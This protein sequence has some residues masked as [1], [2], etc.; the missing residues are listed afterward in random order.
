M[1]TLRPY[2]QAALDA[3]K[4]NIQDH[5]YAALPTGSGKSHVIAHL[6]KW[7][8]DFDETRVVVLT[9]TKELLQ[10]NMEKI[11][12]L[13][14]Y[15]DSSFYCAGLSEKK[16]GTITLASVQSLARIISDLPPVDLFI[17]DEAHRIPH[18]AVGQYR[19]IFAS[20]PGARV[21]GLTATPYRMNGGYLHE[22]EDAIFDR[23][24]YNCRT[25][26]LIKAGYL[27]DIVSK[28]GSH[29][30]DTGGLHT[31]Q[32]EFIV[33]E[34]EAV[35]DTVG[36]NDSMVQDILTRASDRK[37]IMVFCCTVQ[38]CHN[39]AKE[40]RKAG[41]TGVDV[42]TGMTRRHER[43]EAIE[44]FKT[45]AT[46][47]LVNCDVLTTGF[48][49]PR[50]DT[51]VLLRATK[52]PGLYVQIVGRGLRKAEGK[53]NCLLLD[54][55]GN[56]RR[57]GTID[58]LNIEA[59]DSECKQAEPK[60]CPECGLYVA[61]GKRECPG[62]GY[63][64][65]REERKISLSIKADNANPVWAEIL[66]HEVREITY[67]KHDKPGKPPSLRVDYHVGMIQRVPEWI[68]VEHNGY[69]QERAAAWFARRGM[70]MPKT[71]DEALKISPKL[72]APKR[73]RTKQ[74]GRFRR[75]IGY[76]F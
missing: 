72:I 74:E 29:E 3:I 11:N 8:L 70:L 47:I 21:V 57:H 61:L 28:Q 33:S 20:Q 68:C 46:R 64:W 43:A 10:Q 16:I 58:S 31:R 15:V 66:T 76:E 42:V 27:S 65:P 5:I 62:C 53:E 13:M 54:Y 25:D 23:G 52:S 48:D 35:F 32:G 38:H 49:N 14:P 59:D 4:A 55:G 60:A 44:R 39:V 1:S 40:L 2:Q 18:D 12:A 51:I 56:V 34:M 41:E 75:I 22:G 45:G 7:A 17:V 24:V 67:R 37:S 9:H 71:V 69:A 36:V 26:E 50:V 30:A 6:C 19:A 73:I 63:V